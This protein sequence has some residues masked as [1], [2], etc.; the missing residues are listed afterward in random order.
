MHK[1]KILTLVG[2]LLSLS[3]CALVDKLLKKEANAPVTNTA[4]DNVNTNTNQVDT[5]SQNLFYI[6]KELGFSITF[7]PTWQ[8]YQ[9][10]K[11]SN[12]VKFGF[13]EQD[14][15]FAI[16][17]YSKSQWENLQ[18]EIGPKPNYLGENDQNIFAYSQSQAVANETMNARGL[19]IPMIIK[20]FQ[21]LK[22]DP[23]SDWLSYTN[24]KYNYTLK[25]PQNWFFENGYLSPQTI[26]SFEI[27][28]NN[29]PIHFSLYTTDQALA[30]ASTGAPAKPEILHF[31]KID[32]QIK[33][34]KRNNPDSTLTIN[35]LDFKRYDLVDYGRYG[36]DSAGK[37]ILLVG[38]KIN[39]QDLF[40][41]FEW[42]ELPAGQKLEANQAQTFLNIANTFKLN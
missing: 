22:N 25:Y 17:V 42:L 11:S 24:A 36:G 14:N 8:N 40:M 12:G 33:N 1:L 37:V 13:A 28:Y 20:N 6:D 3:G 39:N 34:A 2:L 19:E 5:T 30:S 10:N 31:G 9:A 23:T 29:A 38:P 41:V 27:G 7:L 18:A 21:V 4:S 26:E 32:Y 16:T 35:G 15:L